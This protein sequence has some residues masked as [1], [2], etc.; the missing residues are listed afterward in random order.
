MEPIPGWATWS[1]RSR[2]ERGRLRVLAVANKKYIPAQP[3]S[4]ADEDGLVLTGY[5]RSS[6]PLR[7][8]PPRRLPSQQHGIT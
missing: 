7:K 3:N 4:K 2:I 6:I 1:S 8:P 5:S